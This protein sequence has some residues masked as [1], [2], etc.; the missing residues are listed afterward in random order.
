VP[1]SSPAE[2]RSSG[3]L[4]A[5]RWL[6]RPESGSRCCTASGDRRNRTV[7]RRA[8]GMEAPPSPCP[9]SYLTAK[10]LWFRSAANGSMQG[11]N[12]VVVLKALDPCRDLN[13]GNP[14]SGLSTQIF[15]FGSRLDRVGVSWRSFA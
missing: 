10:I 13:R 8:P 15:F 14:P 9:S 11:P 2:S 12:R 3:S 6:R 5:R 1:G 4:R 7:Q